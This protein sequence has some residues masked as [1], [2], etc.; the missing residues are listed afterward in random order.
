[1]RSDLEKAIVHLLN[2]EHDNAEAMIHKFIVDRARKIHESLRQGDDEAL[3]LEEDMTEEY[4]TEDDLDDEED[5]IE[6]AGDELAGDMDVDMDMDADMDMD[7]DADF[8]TDDTMDGDDVGDDFDID[9]TM[10][11]DPEVDGEMAD[12]LDDLE[13]KLD[14]LSKEFESIMSDQG[15]DLDMGDDFEADAEGDM[16]TDMDMDMD[17]EVEMDGDDFSDDE[18]VDDQ[19]AVAAFDDDMD[20][21]EVEEGALTIHHEDELDES[22]DF[23]DL[24][25]SIT[26]ELD[27]VVASLSDGKEIGAGGSI[28]TNTKSPALQKKPNPMTDGKPVA[29]KSKDH[30]GFERETAPTV[31]DMKK[32]R[33]TRGKSTENMASV[34]KEGSKGAELNKLKSE[35]NTRSTLPEGKKGTPVK[36]TK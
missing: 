12:R 27:K 35:V 7:M 25:E 33:N 13:A 22:D 20:D 18:V 10:D 30:K 14:D 1:M 5:E 2:E 8:D 23:D 17:G 21:E 9:D 15:D 16:D 3:E 32:R 26:S 24:A 6:D 11:A 28:T 31:A 4:F 19:N 34:S 36:R 29:I